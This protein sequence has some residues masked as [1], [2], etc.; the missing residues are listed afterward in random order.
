[1][2]SSFKKLTAEQVRANYREQF[3]VVDLQAPGITDI[4]SGDTEGLIHS[5]KLNAPLNVTIPLWDERPPFPGPVNVLTLEVQLSSSTEW[6][7]AGTPEDI[8]GPADLPDVDFPLKKTIPLSIFQDY[9]GKFQFRYRVKNWND[10]TERESPAAPVTIDRTGPLWVDPLKAVIDIV[11]KP[12][13][14]DVILGKDKGVWCVIPDFTEATNKADVWA[15]VAWLDR[16]PLPTE[17][18]TQFIER[19]TL[20]PPDR[21]VLVPEAAVRKYGSKT[22]YAVA[23]LI[24]KAG[25]RGEMSLPATVPVALGTLPSGLKPCT[26]PLAADGLVDRADAAFPTKVHIEEYTGY[27]DADGIVV[28][29]GGRE[30]ARTSVGAHKPF[31]LTITVPWSDMAAEYN[32]DS[33]THKQ[34]VSV[35]YKVLRGDYPFSSPSAITVVTDFAIPGPVNPDPDPINRTLNSIVFKSS[36]GSSTELVLKDIGEDADAFIELYDD[37]EVGDTLTLYY[38]GEVVDASNNPY[39]IDG[40]ED[41]N[42]VITMVI[43]WTDIER[44][45]VMNDLPLHYTLTHADFDNPQESER[46]TIDVLVEVVDLPEPEFPKEDFP[47]G[48]VNCNSLKRKTPGS[49]EWG[50][51]VHVPKS[52]HLKKDVDVELEWQTYE[53]DGITV[54]AGTDYKE[55]VTVSEQQ[56]ADGVNWFVPYNKCLK[57]SYRPPISGGSGRVEYTIVVSGSPVPSGPAIMVVA[58]FEPDAGGA[59]NDHCVI[60]RP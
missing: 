39:E 36:E 31:P 44:T 30:L 12:V 21:K 18:I 52:T 29:W 34:P 22:Q 24:D 6:V 54:I 48:F 14:T 58:V 7:R 32:F 47:S 51:F 19:S 27:N 17:D 59:G 9:E 49:T 45:P 37:P 53:F 33:A 41:P 2:A 55:T 42:D 60:P 28:K 43:P 50:I 8:P 38:N 5:S 40:T 10:L 57:P 35:D 56:E 1:M 25:N 3:S 11:E 23:I 26:V 46:T 16:V 4:V 15:H 20:L 13:I